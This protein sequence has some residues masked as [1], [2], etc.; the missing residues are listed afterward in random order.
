MKKVILIVAL[1]MSIFSSSFAQKNDINVLLIGNS[2]TF[3]NK[4][5]QMLELLAAGITSET[6]V[7][8]N[9]T[10]LAPGGWS[11]RQHFNEQKEMDIIRKG[12]WDYVILQEQ[13][14]TPCR[15]S[16][17]VIRECY[18]YAHSLDSI[19]HAH[20]PNVKVIFYMTWGHENGTIRPKAEYPINDDYDMMLSRLRSSYLEMTYDNNAWCAPVGMAWDQVRKQMPKIELYIS[21]HF[22][23][24]PEGSYLIASTLLATI[25]QRP[26]VS[27]Y[28]PSVAP[29]DKKMNLSKEQALTMQSISIATVLNN[30]K[31]LNIK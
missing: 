2:F 17:E 20:N 27:N 4:M 5:P 8:I 29:D 22:H 1:V 28:I 12:G 30:K 6:P 13:S 23:P 10:M 19:A 18:P 7:K 16:R 21:D 11:F 24:T 15:H 9:T 14:T 25:L 31:L 3:F 26:F